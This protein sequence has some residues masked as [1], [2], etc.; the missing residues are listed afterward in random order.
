MAPEILEKIDWQQP[1]LLPLQP[2]AA[3]VTGAENWLLALNTAAR[4]QSLRNHR[5]LPLWFVP[6]ME[7]PVGTAYETYISDTGR[8]PTRANLHD[9]FNALVWLAFPQIKAQL[10]ALQAAEISKSIIAGQLD[11]SSVTTRGGLRDAATIFDENAA[12]LIT[13]D[14]ALVDAI[15]EHR[16]TEVFM[17]RRAV[18][19]RDCCVHLFG[20]ALMEKLVSPYKGITAHAWPLMV[21]PAYFAMSPRQRS[22]WVDTAIAKQ[23]TKGLRTADFMPLP[24]LGVPG[25]SEYQNNL[26]YEDKAVF[27]PKGHSRS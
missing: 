27:R 13:C 23:L 14:V 19:E 8:V 26:F 24:V 18:F 9:F 10:N 15:R 20:H 16:W 1:W 11:R 21:G 12:L 25:W 22:G 7:L 17:M 6:Q 2:V 5:D 4:A 3:S